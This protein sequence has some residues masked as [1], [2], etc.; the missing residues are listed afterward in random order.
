MEKRIRLFILDTSQFT[1]E[2]LI[3]LREKYNVIDNRLELSDDEE[4]YISR[5]EKE[6][7]TY[8]AYELVNIKTTL[9][10]MQMKIQNTYDDIDYLTVNKTEVTGFK[11]F[12][13]R[14]KRA[15]Y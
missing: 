9:R 13:K 12:E 5:K 15:N 4:T 2:A 8:G 7:M 1:E 14:N 6:Y 3:E 10:P 11:R